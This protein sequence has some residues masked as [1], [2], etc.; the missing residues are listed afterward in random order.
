MFWVH[1]ESWNGV[2]QLHFEC[3]NEHVGA[4]RCDVHK[5]TVAFDVGALYGD[6]V[7]NTCLIT[8][9]LMRG[10]DFQPDGPGRWKAEH[11][12]AWGVEELVLEA[13]PGGPVFSGVTT[14]FA[15]GTPREEWRYFAGKVER[16]ARVC[17][18]LRMDVGNELRL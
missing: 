2:E 9:D 5:L 4:L 12:I 3:K 14:R 15:F 6:Y 16:I 13:S 1:L 7:P 11:D 17:D 10:F 18:S 8:S